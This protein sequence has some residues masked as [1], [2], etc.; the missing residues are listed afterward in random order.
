MIL[1][2]IEREPLAFIVANLRE[3]DRREIFA[4]RWDDDEAAF[5]DDFLSRPA[6]GHIF[7]LERPIGVIGARP[8]WPGAWAAFMFATD[9]FAKVGKGLTKRA[10]RRIIPGVVRAGCHYATAASLEGHLEAHA[11]I[12]ALGG[13][14]RTILN[15]YG[16]NR[17]NFV[18][19]EWNF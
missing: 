5:V 19:F 4:T 8:L 9:E 13:R 6:M 18:L 7:G 11:W 1:S 14:P 3:W 15:H 17:E 12:R 16:R 2:N 10:I